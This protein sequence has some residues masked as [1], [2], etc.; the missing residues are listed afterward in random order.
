MAK[1]LKEEGNNFYKNKDYENAIKKYARVRM[2]TQT[3]LPRDNQEQVLN[4]MKTS[5][6]DQITA[7]KKAEVVE[8]Q[9]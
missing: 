4:M 5:A 2:F 6:K 8:L 3:F 1:Y 7:E 9:S